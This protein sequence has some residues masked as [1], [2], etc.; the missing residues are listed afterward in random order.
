MPAGADTPTRTGD[1]VNAARRWATTPGEAIY[2]RRS[3]TNPR[4]RMTNSAGETSNPVRDTR[5]LVRNIVNPPS[6]VANPGPETT[7]ERWEIEH[8]WRVGDELRVECDELRRE[9]FE[10]SLE[11]RLLLFGNDLLEASGLVPQLYATCRVSAE[12]LQPRVD[13][14][15]VRKSNASTAVP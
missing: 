14:R 7:N 9:L 12:T 2:P 5:N 4:G 13:A 10:P 6:F 11:S 15:C 3:A 1:R 8:P